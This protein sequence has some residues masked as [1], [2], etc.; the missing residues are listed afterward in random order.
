MPS[1]PLKPHY[2]ILEREISQAVGELQR[3]RN[4]LFLSGIL[5]GFGLGLSL[6][7]IAVTL[8]RIAPSLPDGV[9]A[10]LLANAYTAGFVV[11]IMGRTDLFTEY[12][13][14]AILPVLA[15][16]SPIRDLGRLWALVYTSN[17][18]GG[19]AVAGLIAVLGPS[20]GVIRP[21]V[22]GELAGRLTEHAWWVVLLSGGLAGWLMGLLSWLVSAG[23]D[24]I[25]QI[26]FIWLITAAISLGHLHHAITGSV[27]MFA[28]LFAGQSVGVLDL[29]YFLLWTT[30]GN[31]LG[32]VLFA[33][34][35]QYSVVIGG[36]SA[37]EEGL[38]RDAGRDPSSARGGG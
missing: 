34:L 11:V 30:V 20:L 37:K 1:Q 3:P 6:L 32:G 13:T 5:A 25:S 18:V 8:S 4:G 14:I 36:G 22:F 17:V 9:T 16:I 35:I 2:T 24:T 26:F 21:E 19:V 31:A 23:R 33:V 29:G 15:G 7:L 38:R 10:L 27:E 28:A 12:T